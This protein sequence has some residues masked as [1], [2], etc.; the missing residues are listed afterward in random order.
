MFG[1][2]PIAFQD[3]KQKIHHFKSN[4]TGIS[5]FF[6]LETFV[7]LK[8]TYILLLAILKSVFGSS[9]Q[10]SHKNSSSNTN[11]KTLEER[12]IDAQP[13][14]HLTTEDSTQYLFPTEQQIKL[15]SD[16]SSEQVD[17]IL[18]A[19][20]YAVH[21]G[22][23]SPL[24]I[25]KLNLNNCK[26]INK[27]LLSKFVIPELNMICEINLSKTPIDDTTLIS[28]AENLGQLKT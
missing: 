22:L 28:I 3:A 20:V 13:W 14:L 12:I 4:S 18:K 26:I 9:S 25:S 1:S 16:L 2:L 15:P 7:K 11:K 5:S 21:N 10:K 17:E 24:E 23:V 27:Q 6:T 8:S 19:T